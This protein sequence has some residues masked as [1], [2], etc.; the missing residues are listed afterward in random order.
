M[1]QRIAYTCATVLFPAQSHVPYML[2]TINIKHL[3][4][5]EP[6]HHHHHHYHHYAW[7]RPTAL[8]QTMSLLPPPEAIYP[9]PNTAFTAVQLY[10]KDHRYSIAK[11]TKRPNRI[12]FPARTSLESFT[13]SGSRTPRGALGGVIRP[14]STRREPSAFEIPSSSAP[15]AFNTP[16]EP[17]YIVN[18]GLVW[19]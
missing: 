19:L 3:D 10:A 12:V 13:S 16:Q 4:C 2:S 11:H 1:T 18:S 15:P 8:T 14:T 6:H 7:L 5:F 9:D 17:L